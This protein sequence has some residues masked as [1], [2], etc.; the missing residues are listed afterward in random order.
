MNLSAPI[1]YETPMLTY[2]RELNAALRGARMAPLT[3]GEAMAFFSLRLPI[4][5]VVA[6]VGRARAAA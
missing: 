6:L 2:W 3:F 1:R 5:N 4:A